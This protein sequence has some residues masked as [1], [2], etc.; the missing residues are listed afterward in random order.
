ML[1]FSFL[2]PPPLLS[3]ELQIWIGL[4]DQNTEGVW[5]WTDGTV[6]SYNSF[7]ISEPDGLPDN[8]CV[9]MDPNQGMDWN[10]INCNN[11]EAFICTR[12]IMF[13]K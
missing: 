6:Y 7:A 2:S 5:E 11:Q 4:H 10:D 13:R 12:N 1:P 3:S 8:N 9:A